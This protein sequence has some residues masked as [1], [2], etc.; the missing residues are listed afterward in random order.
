M[1]GKVQIT[2]YKGLHSNLVKRAVTLLINH[3]TGCTLPHALSWY[4]EKLPDYSPERIKTSTAAQVSEFT[5]VQLFPRKYFSFIT[6]NH[7]ICPFQPL[8]M[9]NRLSLLPNM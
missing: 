1:G 6:S 3:K 5:Y 2:A 9:K 7:N 8:G 4:V